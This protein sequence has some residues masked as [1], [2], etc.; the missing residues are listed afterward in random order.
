MRRGWKVL[1]CTAV[2]ALIAAAPLAVTA[3]HAAA[4][5]SAS[6]S[7]TAKKTLR[8]Y[9]GYVTALDKTS[10]TVEKR[11]KKT[12]SKV[13]T[14]HAEMSVTGELEKS[15]HVTVYYRDEAGKAIAHKVIVKSETAA[16][17]SD[18]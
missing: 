15:A 8:Q 9:T 10:L 4:S 1:C 16:A 18:H 7:S 17:V 5:K 14:R 12:E 6:S 13:F 3:S 2:I 11:G